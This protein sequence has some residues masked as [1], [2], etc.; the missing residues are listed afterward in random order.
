M[1]SYILSLFSKKKPKSIEQAFLD[2]FKNH[3]IEI[4]MSSSLTFKNKKGFVLFELDIPNTSIWISK[5]I[6]DCVFVDYNPYLEYNAS[7]DNASL[8]L[9]FL[10]KKHFNIK[11]KDLKY[12]YSLDDT[13]E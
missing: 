10:L 6:W 11:G 8:Y 13:Y 7:Y 1:I 9:H 5:K 3:T 4:Q 2:L 12:Y